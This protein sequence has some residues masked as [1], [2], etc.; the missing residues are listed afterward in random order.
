MMTLENIADRRILVVGDAMLDRYFEGTASRL[1]PEAPVPVL[2]VEQAFERAGGAANVAINIAALGA[3]VSLVAYVGDDSDAD[4]LKRLLDQSGVECHFITASSACTIVK[5]RALAM[6]QQ[7]MRLDFEDSFAG[8]DHAALRERVACLAP[9]HDLVVLSDYAKGT[10]HD[11][12]DLVE[13]LRSHHIPILVDPKGTDYSRYKGATLITPNEHEFIAAGGLG[14]DDEDR[15][16]SAQA[17]VDRLGLAALLVT[18]GEKGMSLC[19]PS[20]EMHCIPAEAREVFDVTGAG[21]TVIATLAAT[22]A[23]GFPF[24]DAMHWANQAAAIVV[25]RKGTAAVNAFELQ[26]RIEAGRSPHDRS[27]AFSAIAQARRAGEAIVM[28]NGCFDILHAGHVTYLEQAK[29]LGDRL[30][31]AINDDASVERLKGAGRPVNPL[32][33]RMAVLEALRAVD[34]VLP[35]TGSTGIDGTHEDTPRDIID[36]VQ[37]DILVKG[38]DYDIDTIVGA[39]AVLARGGRVEVLPFVEGRSTSAIIERAGRSPEVEA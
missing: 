10:L 8:E 24:L 38:G 13:D 3:A 20:G 11:V 34:W 31:I 23:L 18:R 30:V 32:G 6:R 9:G 17:M 14:G 28:T 35:F 25:A 33:D 27:N 5:L 2:K 21:D 22:I 26:S 36:R 39:D 12:A 16:T 4:L 37:P 29:A 19:L 15:R 1:S 7:I